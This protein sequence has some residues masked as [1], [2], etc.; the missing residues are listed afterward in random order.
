MRGDFFLGPTQ[1]DL[2]DTFNYRVA[3]LTPG[4]ALLTLL[5][6]FHLNQF[7]LNEARRAKRS[8]TLTGKVMTGTCHC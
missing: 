2:A 3:C 6:Y 4:L 1:F 8:D 5:I 7:D